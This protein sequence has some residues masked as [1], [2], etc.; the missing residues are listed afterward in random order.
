MPSKE[1]PSH[2]PTPPECPPTRAILPR[3][4]WN[5]HWFQVEDRNVPSGPGIRPPTW[6][7]I[8]LER[9]LGT[10]AGGAGAGDGAVDTGWELAAVCHVR[11]DAWL[12][13]RRDHPLVF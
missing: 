5:L 4:R 8:R 2:P 10:G 9:G 6:E 12:H 1:R 11:P 7:R 13:P 3:S